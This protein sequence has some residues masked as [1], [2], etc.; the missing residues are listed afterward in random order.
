[1]STV[2]HAIY[3][4]MVKFH[5]RRFNL[6]Q[7]CIEYFNLSFVWKNILKWQDHNSLEWNKMKSDL[8]KTFDNFE[9]NK[10]FGQS[11]LRRIL[12]KFWKS[13]ILILGVLLIQFF[14]ITILNVSQKYAKSEISIQDNFEESNRMMLSEDFDKRYREFC[15]FSGSLQIFYQL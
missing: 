1:M 11:I 3:N 10:F 8:I 6:R 2:V 7:L 5:N 9:Q 4:N 12:L 14:I 15:S 13:R